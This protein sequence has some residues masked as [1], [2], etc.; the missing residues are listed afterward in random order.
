MA[1][2]VKHAFAGGNTALG[3]TNSF[4]SAFQGARILYLLEG[5]PGTGKSTIIQ[6]IADGVRDQGA[7][8]WWFHNPLNHETLDG[9]WIP[10]AAIGVVDKTACQDAFAGFT[11][12]EIITVSLDR[13]VNRGLLMPYLEELQQ[14]HEQIEERYTSATDSFLHTLRIHDDWEKYYIDHIQF[15][16]ADQVTEELKSLITEA[17][18][19][20]P[21]TRHLYLG[22]ATSVGAVDYVMNLTEQLQRR[23]F[24]KG[25]PGSG[26]STMLKKI[27]AAGEER[28][29]DVEVYH[30]G[31]DPNSLDMVIF[32]SLGLAIFDSTAPHEHFPS[33]DGDEIL[34]MY[35]RTIDEGT[36]ERYADEIANVKAQYAASMRASLAILAEVKQQRDRLRTIYGEVTDYSIVG[37]IGSRLCSNVLSRL[38]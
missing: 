9:L 29:Q 3:R 21:V 31:F 25:R 2:I 5:G 19:E 17:S 27:V 6:R 10:S 13:A 35:V 26:K 30:C 28:R 18:L 37:D 8:A 32:P 11:E 24:V 34:D 14:I 22:A 38:K 15:D 36:D 20:R 23:I 16:A 1:G 7:Q 12:T 33:R 4:A